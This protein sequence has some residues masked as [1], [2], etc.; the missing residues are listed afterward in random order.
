MVYY[1][2]M[3]LSYYTDRAHTAAPKLVPV[4]WGRGAWNTPG[5]VLKFVTSDTIDSDGYYDR[6]K[7]R[8]YLFVFLSLF[9][10]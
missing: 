4:P 3:T 8:K 10:F 1:S 9:L 2:L 7:S 6:S 5:V